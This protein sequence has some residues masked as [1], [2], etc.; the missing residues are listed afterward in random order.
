LPLNIYK[1][2]VTFEGGSTDYIALKKDVVDLPAFT[3][4]PSRNN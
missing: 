1:L 3:D 2:I 4:T